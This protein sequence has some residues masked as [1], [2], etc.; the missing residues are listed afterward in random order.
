[1]V[2]QHVWLK[3]WKI[4]PLS[5]QTW[6]AGNLCPLN[7][8]NTPYKRVNFPTIYVSTNICLTHV[9]NIYLHLALMYDKCTYA[10]SPYMEPM[11]V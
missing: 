3:T 8:G 11:G 4:Y 9:W 6:Q 1:M 5:K 7:V 10:N 2:N